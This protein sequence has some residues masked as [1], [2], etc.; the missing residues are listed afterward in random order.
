VN[1]IF[2]TPCHTSVVTAPV[3]G[4]SF[5]SYLSRIS[6][7][8]RRSASRYNSTCVG[9][10][11]KFEILTRF[12]FTSFLN[13]RHTFYSLRSGTQNR[14]ERQ[15]AIYRLISQQSKSISFGWN[16]IA[17][18]MTKSTVKNCCQDSHDIG[19]VKVLR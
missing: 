16:F 10:S 2:R 9:F 15:V 4:A 18:L 11:C 1:F 19:F 12:I 8:A 5:Y 14:N 3:R 7:L 17:F 6:V 13:N